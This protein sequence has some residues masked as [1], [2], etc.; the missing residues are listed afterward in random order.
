MEIEQI[1]AQVDAFFE[2]NRGEAAEE[3]LLRSIEQAVVEKEDGCLLQLLNEIIGYY[4]V[5]GAFDQAYLFSEKAISQAEKMGLQ[6]MVPYATTLLNAANAYRA[7]GRLQEALHLFRQVQ[8]IYHHQLSPDNMLVAG[9]E[10]NLS[11]LYQEMGDFEK[12]RECLLRALDI[13]RNKDAYY[14]VGVT[15]ANLA[16]T[17]VCLGRM[18]EAKE[19]AVNSMNTF[20]NI[21]VRD[22]HYG[23]A[24]SALGNW[25]FQKKEFSRAEECF[26]QAMELVETGVGRNADYERL[27]A[28]LQVC[29]RLRR[30]ESNTELTGLQLAEAY[31]ETYGRQ[32]IATRF[33]AYENKIAVGF[34]G[35]G[36]DCFGF[37]DKI[38]RDHDWGPGFCLWVTDETWEEIGESLQQAYGELP[39][40]FMGYRR[41][42]RVNALGKRGVLRISEFYEGLLGAKTYE[43]ISWKEVSDASFAAAVN[44]K[45]FRDEEGIFSG[46]RRKLQEGYPKDILYLKIAQS[47]TKFAQSAEYNFPRMLDR[48]DKLTANMM[49]WDGIREAMLLQHYIEDRYPPHEKWLRTSL[50]LSDTG[51]K[52]TEFLERICL[53]VAGDGSELLRQ[54]L[55]RLGDFFAREM[56]GLD[57]ISDIDSYLAAHSEELIY[58]ASL[59]SRSHTELVEMVAD[60]EF[61]AFDKV[62]NEGGRA[63][64]QNDWKTFSIMRK[65]QYLTWN[66]TMLMQYL[67]D[68]RREYSRGHNLIEEKYGRMME[69]TAPERYQEIKDYFPELSPEKKGIIEQICAMQVGWMEEFANHYPFLADNARSIHTTEDNPFNT[70]YETYLRGELGTYSDKML[71]LYGRYIVGYAKEGKNL[72]HDI[73]TNCVHFYGYADIDVAE[74]K[75]KNAR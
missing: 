45:V 55:E 23:A 6:G 26:R 3:L 65:S 5:S 47:A 27:E 9:L 72:A 34:V 68:F 17:C 30:E 41:T 7:G 61:E 59:F 73:M 24:L 8:E 20:E 69:S 42:A 19:H 75:I 14:E 57:I 56:Y 58:K 22:S 15:Y 11:L 12:A 50:L 33:P 66:R 40:E 39:D 43:E 67:F 4:R 38:S 18:D 71:E 52:V 51:R 25:Y 63:S 49:V 16:A 46:F 54:Q 31:Y 37:D 32:M 13:V 44:G 21:G 70:S 74:E 64:C 62:K 36:S 60:L 1:L 53:S 2:E 29:E 10:N 35:P 48:G 28:N